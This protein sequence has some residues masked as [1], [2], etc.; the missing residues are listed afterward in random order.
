MKNTLDIIKIEGQITP[1]ELSAIEEIVK[2]TDKVHDIIDKM[3]TA[4]GKMETIHDE[5]GDHL[6]FRHLTKDEVDLI[7]KCTK[8][9]GEELAEK[10]TKDYF[11]H[12]K[13]KLPQEDLE[14]F[15]YLVQN[16]GIYALHRGMSMDGKQNGATDITDPKRALRYIGQIAHSMNKLK[17]ECGLHGDLCLKCDKCLDNH[18]HCHKPFCKRA[19]VIEQPLP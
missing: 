16:V 13:E 19:F 10:V 9:L 1:E 8:P 3:M 4:K 18:R 15:A 2:D 14:N 12:F 5:F 6:I 7:M 17:R 11:K